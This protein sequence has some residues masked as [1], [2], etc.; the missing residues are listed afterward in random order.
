MGL[1]ITYHL[2]VMLSASVH[3]LLIGV[4]GRNLEERDRK[5]ITCQISAWAVL[6]GAVGFQLD[7]SLAWEFLSK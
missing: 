3:C 5:A 1:L 4:F 7:R 2:M 6:F